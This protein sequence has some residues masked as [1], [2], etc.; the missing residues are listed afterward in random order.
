M[1]AL[2]AYPGE[3]LIAALAELREALEFEQT[4]SPGLAKL[5]AEIEASDIYDLQERYVDLFDR[6]PSLSLHLFEHVHGQTRDRGQAMVD[7]KSLYTQHGLILDPHELPDYLPAFLEYVSIVDE[8]EARALVAETAG[9]LRAIGARLDKRGSRYAAVFATL[10]ASCGEQG[11]PRDTVSDQDIRAEDDPAALDASWAEEPVFGPPAGC[12]AST[13]PPQVAP[14]RL[15]RLA[16][17]GTDHALAGF[18]DRGFAP[19]PA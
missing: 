3:A 19:I 9:V 4:L 15:Q 17:S 5:I 8:G 10:L 18:E 11:W 7:L 12:G 6:V 14:I 2:L 1:A 13:H 16:K